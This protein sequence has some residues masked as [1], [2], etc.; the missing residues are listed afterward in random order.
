MYT[1]CIIYARLVPALLRWWLRTCTEDDPLE[2]DLD[3][4]QTE[5]ERETDDKQHD[6]AALSTVLT[7]PTHETTLRRRS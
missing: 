6:A 3:D 4:E 2:I 1:I 7:S 5:L